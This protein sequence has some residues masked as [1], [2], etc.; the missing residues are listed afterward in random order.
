VPPELS[1]L[2]KVQLQGIS[3]IGGKMAVQ[4]RSELCECASDNGTMVTLQEDNSSTNTSI[5]PDSSL[6]SVAAKE[7][8][9]VA[10][11]NGVPTAPLVITLY[12]QRR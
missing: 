3:F 5:T 10:E 1:T 7:Q 11:E 9:L 8:R 4:Y 12:H 6:K 2:G